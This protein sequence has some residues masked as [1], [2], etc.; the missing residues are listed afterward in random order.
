MPFTSSQIRNIAFC[1]TVLIFAL[2]VGLIS[3]DG[4]LNWLPTSLLVFLAIVFALLGLVVVVLTV[5]LHEARAQKAFLLLAGISAVA[6][7]VCAVLHNVVYGLF[8]LWFGEG[9]WERH[10]ADEPVFFILAIVVFP[11]LFLV[12]TVGSLVFLRKASKAR[13]EQVREAR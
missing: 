2:F 5:R 1:V 7:P 9:L 13:S 6:I 3:L 4:R 12:G 8:I 11:A 10:G